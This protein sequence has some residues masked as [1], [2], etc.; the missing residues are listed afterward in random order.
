V[1]HAVRTNVTGNSD[2]WLTTPQTVDLE[3]LK[4]RMITF[5]VNEWRKLK[6]TT[7]KTNLAV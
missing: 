6:E 5:K 3:T 4:N 1:S 2:P 7:K